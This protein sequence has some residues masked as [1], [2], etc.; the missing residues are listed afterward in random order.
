MSGWSPRGPAAQVTA[1]F[2]D[3][4]SGLYKNG[5]MSCQGFVAVLG[6]RAWNKDIVRG[7][8]GFIWVLGTRI[9]ETL[10]RAF[11]NELH[12]L[13]CHKMETWQTGFLEYGNLLSNMISVWD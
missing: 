11:A 9:C 10:P 5:Y 7:L 6:F 1:F 12:L 2:W 13:S 3:F 4:G 8:Q